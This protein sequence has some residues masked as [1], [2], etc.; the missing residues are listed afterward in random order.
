MFYLCLGLVSRNL[1]DTARPIAYD[2]AEPLQLHDQVL[3]YY[4]EAFE[5]VI[6]GKQCIVSQ[7]L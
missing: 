3:Q 4:P 2:H 1:K 6:P 5:Y 7:L